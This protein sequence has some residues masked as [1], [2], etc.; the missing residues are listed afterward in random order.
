MPQTSALKF[1]SFY[2]LERY[3]C[4]YNSVF[5]PGGSADCPSEKFKEDDY[6]DIPDDP[7]LSEEGHRVAPDGGAGRSSSEVNAMLHRMK[8]RLETSASPA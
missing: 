3:V 2:S 5:I 4:I 6:A 8:A 1:N 7:S